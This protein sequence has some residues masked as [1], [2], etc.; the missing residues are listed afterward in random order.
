[1]NPIRSELLTHHGFVH[2]FSTRAGGVSEAPFDTLNLGRTVGDETDAVEE[3]RERFAAEVGLDPGRMFELHQVHGRE[4]RRVAATDRPDEVWKQQADALLTRVSGSALAVR[5]A[6]CVPVLLGHPPSGTV[7]AAHAGWRGAVAGVLSATVRAMA[8]PT[9][10]IVAAIGPHI[11]VGA[12][13]VGEDVASQLEHAAQ[14]GVVVDRT[15]PKPH[16]DLTA[17]I[18][19]QLTKAGLSEAHIDDVG[20]CTHAD[21]LRFFSH[22]RDRGNTG[23]HLS[24]IVCAC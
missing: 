19:G 5:T 7:A 6:D 22:R 10:E 4:T 13:E 15:R 24:V 18:T 2:A 12:F 20:G 21:P 17:L 11:R 23:R 8:V 16:G 14:G 1:M 3:N 9:Q